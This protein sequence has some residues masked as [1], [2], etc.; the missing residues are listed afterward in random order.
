MAYSRRPALFAVLLAVAGCRSVHS[1]ATTTPNKQKADQ[2]II[3]KSERTLTLMNRGQVLKTYKLALGGNPVGAKEKAGD[4]K[5]R[6]T[7]RADFISPSTSLIQML[8]T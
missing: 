5:T 7:L 6:R 2:I 3:V 4:K 8:R 1:S